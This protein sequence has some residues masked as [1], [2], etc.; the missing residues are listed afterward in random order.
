VDVGL[1]NLINLVYIFTKYH[2][3]EGTKLSF[4]VHLEFLDI[5]H[6]HMI[7]LKESTLVNESIKCLRYK[8]LRYIKE[9]PCVHL[10]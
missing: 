3:L 5:R 10:N 7:N 2:L 1:A 9:N 8:A 6:K 4:I